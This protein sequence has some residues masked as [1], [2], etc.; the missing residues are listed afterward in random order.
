MSSKPYRLREKTLIKLYE[1]YKVEVHE[2][3]QGLERYKNIVQII[4][5][6]YGIKKEYLPLKTRMREVVRSRWML[7][8]FIYHDRHTNISW[9]ELTDKLYLFDADHTTAIHAIKDMRYLISKYDFEIELWERLK[10]LL[11]V[12]QKDDKKYFMPKISALQFRNYAKN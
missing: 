8:Y 11:S 6:A 4:C 7:I 3:L 2:K 1:E 9:Q 12:R 10:P 5:E